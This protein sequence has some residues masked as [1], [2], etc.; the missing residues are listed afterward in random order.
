[1]VAMSKPSIPSILPGQGTLLAFLGRGRGGKSF[2]AACIIDLLRARGVAVLVADGDRTNATLTARYPDASRPENISDAAA[3]RWL[4]NIIAAV[5]DQRK[6]VVLDMGGGDTILFD[7][8][9]ELGLVPLLEEN[10]VIVSAWHM[11]G[12]APDDTSVLEAAEQDALFA[13]AR[14]A[15]VLNQGASGEGPDCTFTR[16]TSADAYRAA[17]QRGAVQMVLPELKCASAI[18]ARQISLEQA[19]TNEAA[20]EFAPLLFVDRR[21]VHVFR[22]QLADML[23][24]V[25]TWLP[26]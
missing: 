7:L 25:R 19:E 4:E 24:S 9:R 1:M 21:R 23:V 13:P 11:L 18:Q 12:N 10:G 8:A 3:R 6:V 20:S 22:A 2:L 17:L 16:T 5:V 26:S 15:L 14:T